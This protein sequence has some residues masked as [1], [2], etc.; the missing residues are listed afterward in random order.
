[1]SP[2]LRSPIF[3]PLLI[4]LIATG[5]GDCVQ[6][7]SLTTS[8]YDD[9]GG[10]ANGLSDVASNGGGEEPDAGDPLAD[11]AIESRCSG[12][13]CEEEELCLSSTCI[14]P[15]DSCQH[16]SQCP[17][18]QFC[19]T[20]MGNCL[21][22]AAGTCLYIPDDDS[23]DPVVEVAWEGDENTPMPAH[24]QVMMAP[25]V[26]DITGNGI[27]DIVFSTFQG[28]NYNSDS[29]LRAIDG[30]TFETVFD[31]TDPAHRV[32]GAS[33]VAIG[34]IDGDGR[35]EIVAIVSGGQGLIAFDDYSTGFAFKWQTDAFNMSWDGAYLA[36]LDGNGSV[37]VIGAN[38]VYDGATGDF[39]CSNAEVGATPLNSVVADLNGNG[40]LDIV[41]AGG[42]FEFI[43]NPD[44]T[45]DCPTLFVYPD[46]LTGYPAVA[47]FGT[48]SNGNY[49][50]GDFDGLP[51]IAVVT[52]NLEHAVKLH[53]GRT[54]ERIWSAP[55]PTDAHPHY[56]QP[57]CAGRPGAGPPT[58]ADF[59][60]DG[61]PNVATAG[62]CFYV[63]FDDQGQLMWRMAT[64]DF[65]SRVT[66]SSVF[67]FQGNGRAEVV[68]G[69]ECFLRV[70]DGTGN[71]DGSTEVLFEIANT[72]GTTRELPVIV[73]VNGDFHANIV[74]IGNDYAGGIT[75][76]CSQ[77][78]DGFDD[79][80]GA[81]RGIRVISDI[82]N[83]WVATRPVWNQHAYSVTNVCDGL[84]DALCPG[85]ENR[86]GAIPSGR[87][88]NW[89]V[90]YLNNYRQNVQGEGLFYAPDL[91]ITD[92]TGRC[93]AQGFAID[94]TVANQGSR[95]VIE[96][97]DVAVFGIIEGQETLIAVLQTTQLLPPG[98]GETLTYYWEDSPFEVGQ[99]EEVTLIARANDDGTGQR[100]YRECNEDNNEGTSLAICACQTDEDCRFA[101]YCTDTGHCRPVPG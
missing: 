100:R 64:Q 51:E 47:D 15:G 99:G 96:G 57:T 95:S 56:D 61:R 45:V 8:G 72:T 50:F 69:D 37:E 81:S 19:E 21:P 43:R 18:G 5:C 39:L 31:I 82:E 25:S 86:P 84:D 35:N 93:D 59:N 76:G 20:A 40:N 85:V 62:A 3:A 44:G 53:D 12:V 36:D 74:L 49:Q 38:R 101:H 87:V 46:G 79:L 83:R 98:S 24:N 11:C 55:M 68:Y 22:D 30:R 71:P 28:S 6:T 52:Y 9:A 16:S 2:L 75:T 70:Y 7:S 58:I 97:L 29:V 77:R 32:S 80:G 27:P 54:G 34:D 65:S 10:D 17:E 13:C 89:N 94:V 66:G 91:V 67:D 41:A 48:F 60:G 26:V 63:V 14:V 23:F 90:D 78:W 92:I 33:S 42:A 1:M 4:L 88:D 73:D